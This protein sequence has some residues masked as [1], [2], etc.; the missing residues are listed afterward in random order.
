MTLQLSPFRYRRAMPTPRPWP[1]WTFDRIETRQA[2]YH[3]IKSEP[4]TGAD[5][6]ET[7]GLPILEAIDE[8]RILENYKVIRHRADD[9]GV[10]RWHHRPGNA[11]DLPET[12][13]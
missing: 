5:I 6:A 12:P 8:L 1:T 9:L 3:R 2:I 4:R 11:W 10:I 13:F 7:T